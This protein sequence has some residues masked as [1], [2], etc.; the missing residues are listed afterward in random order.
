VERT[1]M[2]GYGDE[3]VPRTVGESASPRAIDEIVQESSLESFP[4]SDPPAWAAGRV[5]GATAQEENR[6]DERLHGIKPSS[7]ASVDPRQLPN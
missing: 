7:T 2:T 3:D 5:E 1:I 6:C 4:A